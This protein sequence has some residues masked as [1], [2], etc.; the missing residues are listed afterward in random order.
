VENVDGD[1][2]MTGNLSLNKQSNVIGV[3]CHHCAYQIVFQKND[4][5]AYEEKKICLECKNEVRGY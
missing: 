4:V 3:E 1:F 2:I 5:G